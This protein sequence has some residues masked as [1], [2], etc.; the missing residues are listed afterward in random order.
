MK[1]KKI[2]LE[3]RIFVIFFLITFL[4]VAVLIL[5][6]WQLA[7][8]GIK[9]NEDINIRKIFSDYSYAQNDLMKKSLKI[10]EEVASNQQILSAIIRKNYSEI[11]KNISLYLSKPNTRNITIFNSKKDLL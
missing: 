1:K 9:Q 4:I 7:K 6:E 2:G 8:Y 5:I 10:L 11:N 3:K